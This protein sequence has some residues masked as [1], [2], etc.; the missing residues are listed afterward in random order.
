MLLN[1]P[2]YKDSNHITKSW[3]RNLS[4]IELIERIVKAGD[5]Q[6][7]E[8]FHNNRKV[9]CFKN[10]QPLR[11]IEYLDRLRESTIKMRW[12]SRSSFEIADKAFDMTLDKF[13]NLPSKTKSNES[14]EE[15]ISHTVKQEGSNCRLY[16]KAF[17][18]RADNSFRIKPPIGAL[19]QE[20][21]ASKI[22]QGFVS[23]HFHLSWREAE[24]KSNPFWSRYYWN[25]K[26]QKICVRLPVS[27]KGRKRREWL[28]QNIKNIDL[29]RP[30]ERQRIQ[31]IINRKLV[32]ER[33]VP[34][35]EVME[36]GHDEIS[37]IQVDWEKTSG[38]SLG[39]IVAEEKALNIQQQRP[40]IR[41]L[42]ETQLRKMILQIFEDISY[43]DYKDSE[44]AKDFGL[45]KATYSRFAGSRWQQS[46]SDVPD[47]WR[48]TA[49][50][51]KDHP[52]FRQ[53]AQEMGLWDQVVTTVKKSTFHKGKPKTNE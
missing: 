33:F 7:L 39:Q 15:K 40:S 18:D 52:I 51:L 28:E 3:Y 49:Q 17:L 26:N 6:A 2:M 5:L 10:G 36:I 12:Q 44:I 25:V 43:D 23:H 16:F 50:V 1:E 27:L 22:I 48:N 20:A 47:L 53:V 4:L 46:E 8:E 14:E 30:Q 45:T 13:N 38:M 37:L 41:A 9:F 35:N 31:A 19:E 32:R 42:G 29:N 24:R 11:F 34:F 21:R